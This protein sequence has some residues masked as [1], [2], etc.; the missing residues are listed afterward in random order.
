MVNLKSGNYMR[1]KF[2]FSVRDTGGSEEKIRVLPSTF[3]TCNLSLTDIQLVGQFS[4]T[5][6]TDF[7][8]QYLLW[9]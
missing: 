8:F 4:K 7:A 6:F 9:S 5:T 3:V 1:N 2:F